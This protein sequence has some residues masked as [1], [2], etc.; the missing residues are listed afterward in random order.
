MDCRV[1]IGE[2]RA[3]YATLRYPSGLVTVFLG[4]TNYLSEG[5]NV[6]KILACLPPVIVG[7]IRF[8]MSIDNPCQRITAPVIFASNKSPIP[9]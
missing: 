7:I 8:I 3:S 1:K 4:L 9:I 5:K 6:V 2:T